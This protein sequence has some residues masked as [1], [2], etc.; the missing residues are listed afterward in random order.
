MDKNRSFYI[1]FFAWVVAFV[2]TLG[3]LFFSEIM[4]FVPCSLCWYQRICMYPLVVILGLSLFPVE[5]KALKYALPISCIGWIL[6]FYHNLLHWEIIPES[7]APCRQGIPCSTI[8]I[9]WLGF[10]T[11]PFLSLVAFTL[12]ILFLFKAQK[13]LVEDYN[14]KT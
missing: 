2:A 4:D 11:I 14:G 5:I 9:N 12:I 8:Y 3:S 13:V 7:A 6:A 1:L 10:V